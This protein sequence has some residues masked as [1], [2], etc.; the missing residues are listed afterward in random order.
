MFS[1]T[2]AGINANVHR[3]PPS[4]W[5]R[6]IQWIPA[7]DGSSP[8]IDRGRAGDTHV[9]DVA[10]FGT[11]DEVQALQA[12]IDANSGVLT[13]SNVNCQLFDPLID[14][15]QP[16]SVFVETGKTEQG[17]FVQD[18]GGFYEFHASLR[19]VSYSKVAT[20]GSLLSLR[21]RGKFEAGHTDPVFPRWS[22]G[23]VP[24]PADA[25][26]PVGTWSQDF[27]QNNAESEA[28]LSYF[29]TV[30]GKAFL[31]PTLP[32]VTYPFGVS[33]GAVP[34]YCHAPVVQWRR[35]NLHYGLIRVAFSKAF[36]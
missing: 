4:P 6:N 21:L 17:A 9:C 31:F 14:H 32:G 25:K 2:I 26:N 18:E 15:T 3:Y 24:S 36:R 34:L 12:A 10:F 28:I 5:G 35:A 33:M 11:R 1:F 8:G 20:V 30:R 29:D 27:Y 22:Y 19:A 13:I 7:A 16:I 23:N